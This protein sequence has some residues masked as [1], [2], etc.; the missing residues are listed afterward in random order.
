MMDIDDTRTTY[1][2]LG[3]KLGTGTGWDGD[4]AEVWWIYDFEPAEGVNL[5][6]GDLYID[7]TAGLIGLANEDGEVIGED[8]CFVLLNIPKS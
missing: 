5:P 7:G 4:P 1:S 2:F 3:R 6:S 8:I